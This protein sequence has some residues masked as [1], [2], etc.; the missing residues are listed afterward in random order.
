MKE[1]YLPQPRDCSGLCAA[2]A[3][4]PAMKFLFLCIWF[5]P[6]GKTSDLLVT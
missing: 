6:R 5:L 1:E 4:T 2:E 3:T